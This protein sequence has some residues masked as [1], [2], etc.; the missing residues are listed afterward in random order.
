MWFREQQHDG[1]HDFDLTLP[2]GTTVALEVTSSRNQ[3]LEET[4]AAI[5]QAKYGG[6]LIPRSLCRHDWNIHPLS[7]AH[8]KL[9]RQK[10]DEYLAQIEADGL[11]RFFYDSDGHEYESVRR[12]FDDLA[13]EAG[14]SAASQDILERGRCN[15]NAPELASPTQTP[16]RAARFTLI[17]FSRA[18]WRASESLLATSSPMPKKT[19]SGVCP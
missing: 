6:P 12:I 3:R 18:D 2:G 15:S 11:D 14:N 19:S 4:Y 17:R 13:V 5:R 8:I 7:N 1:S 9:V 10:A 16:H